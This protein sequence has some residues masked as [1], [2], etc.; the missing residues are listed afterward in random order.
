MDLY[1]QK[2]SLQF[3]KKI[4]FNMHLNNVHKEKIKKNKLQQKNLMQQGEKQ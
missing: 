1:C 4:I 2:S 3:D